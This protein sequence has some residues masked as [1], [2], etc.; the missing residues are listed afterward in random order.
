MDNN[1][2]YNNPFD[3]M[4][5]ID[6]KQDNQ[7]IDN[8]RLPCKK[9][10]YSNYTN[11]KNDYDNEKT[12]E[13]ISTN[14]INHLFRCLFFQYISK[15]IS[16]DNDNTVEIINKEIITKNIRN[17]YDYFEKTILW[18]HFLSESQKDLFISEFGKAQRVYLTLNRFL[19]L[20]KYK[21]ARQPI[22]TDLFL[23]P[24]D[25]SKNQII[26]IYQEKTKYLFTVSDL[27]RIIKNALFYS[28][29]KL[30][31]EP[32]IPK[33]PYNN[34]IFTYSH[35]FH[36]YYHLKTKCMY[37][38]IPLYFELFYK[39]DFN[40]NTFAIYNDLY[41][42]KNIIK[43]FIFNKATYIDK[44]VM[45]NLKYM[46]SEHIYAKKWK[47]HA[48]F[49]K[50]EL[51]DIFRP[52]LYLYYLVWYSDCDDTQSL[53]Y[54]SSLVLLLTHFYKMNPDFG[55]MT[56]HLEKVYEPDP[57]TG[58]RKIISPYFL[59]PKRLFCYNKMEKNDSE[60]TDDSD[61]SKDSGNSGSKDSDNSD[62]SGSKESETKT[63]DNSESKD[64]LNIIPI[65]EIERINSENKITINT[66]KSIKSN[67]FEWKNKDEPTKYK[68]VRVMTFNKK[69][70]E[71]NTRHY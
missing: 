20:Y 11:D 52:Y 32:I 39:F 70:R 26:T 48:E 25:D 40:V 66:I 3:V 62:N 44:E 42:Q 59:F 58:I 54:K 12:E 19:F 65:E 18:N 23:N 22:Q 46:L 16:K 21:R 61:D 30:E 34:M 68:I 36:L 38:Q 10:S 29:Y 28:P 9:R 1:P 55:K 67:R 24:I 71:C 27:L 2:F 33:N 64:S 6:K 63:S 53:Y 50:N 5:N 14:N 56:V 7:E 13:Q 45:L 35:F 4:S 41:I 31:S 51:L 17:K 43:E 15:C 57:V 47:I 8:T 69:R 37:T 60:D 49:P